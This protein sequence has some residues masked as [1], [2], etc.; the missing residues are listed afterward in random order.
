MTGETAPA[1]GSS[2]VVIETAPAAN[3]SS[4][5]RRPCRSCGVGWQLGNRPLGRYDT[6]PVHRNGWARVDR[7]RAGEPRDRS[8][9]PLRHRVEGDRPPNRRCGSSTA[10][11]ATAAMSLHWVIGW[12]NP[13]GETDTPS[14]RPQRSFI[15]GSGPSVSKRSGHTPIQATR[16]RKGFSCVAASKMSARSSCSSRRIAG[17]AARRTP[18][19]S[20]G[21]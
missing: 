4:S 8:S 16:H 20:P 18:H 21:A 2:G 14:K 9:A 10:L 5:R 3:A 1:T 13:I 17:N 7:S 6:A 12:A 11:R 15:T 19:T